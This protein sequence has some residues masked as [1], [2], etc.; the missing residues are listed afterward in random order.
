MA[1]FT[2]FSKLPIELRTKI[3]KLTLQPRIIEIQFTNKKAVYTKSKLPTTLYVSKE[4]RAAVEK[5]YPFCFGSVWHKYQTRF[6]FDLDTIFLNSNYYNDFCHFFT[7]AGFSELHEIRYLAIDNLCQHISNIHDPDKEDFKKL[8]KVVKSMKA[9]QE[10][11]VTYS[12]KNFFEN[13]L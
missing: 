13:C 3:W 10:M 5:F 8:R 4:S 11:S 7:L 6:N 12:A 9:L 2:I 1:L